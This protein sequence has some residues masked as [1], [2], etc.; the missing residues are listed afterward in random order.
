MSSYDYINK[1]NKSKV[2]GAEIDT[3][4]NQFDAFSNR[5]YV[6]T[7]EEGNPVVLDYDRIHRLSGIPA[8][9][10]NPLDERD[11]QFCSAGSDP[12]STTRP[13]NPLDG[14]DPQLCS[15]SSDPNSTTRPYNPLEGRSMD[16]RFCVDVGA[17]GLRINDTPA[18]FCDFGADKSAIIKANEEFLSL[19]VK[20]D[21]EAI[22][23]E[24]YRKYRIP[25]SELISGFNSFLEKN[26]SEYKCIKMPNK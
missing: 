18:S 4:T 6:S 26:M 17:G 7:D 8:R 21:V 1:K 23:N 11:P 20:G 25:K 9:P 12:N 10:Y 5:G 24:L 15:V 19:V 22:L 2:D 3:S 14:R 13:Y 16:Q